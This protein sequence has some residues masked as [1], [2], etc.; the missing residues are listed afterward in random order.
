IGP[1]RNKHISCLA[2]AAFSFAASGLAFAADMAVKMPVKTPPPAP[3]PGY[4]WA[5][6]YFGGHVGYRWGEVKTDLTADGK[7]SPHN[8][9]C[10]GC[11]ITSVSVSFASAVS[12]TAHPNG[13]I[14]GGQIGYNYQFSPDGVLG[15]EADIQ[16]SG[17]RGSSQFADPFVAPLCIAGASAP[18][19]C[20]P[21]PTLPLPGT[22]LTSYQAKIDWFGTFRG[23][24]GWLVNDQLLVYAT[25]GLAYGEVAVSGNANIS[26]A[27]PL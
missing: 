23:R 8:V 17:E 20:A 14:G 22:V 2:G 11:G 5:G 15:F 19:V 26:A 9:V 6:W 16:G 3:A 24:L 4:S 10:S 27:L 25:G 18:G 21:G 13:V 7:L 1:V 12:N